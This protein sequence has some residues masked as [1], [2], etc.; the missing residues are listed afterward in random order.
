MLMKLRLWLLPLF[1]FQRFDLKVILLSLAQGFELSVLVWIWL[2]VPWIPL[3]LCCSHFTVRT[4]GPPGISGAKANLGWWCGLEL[5]NFI[6]LKAGVS[7]VWQW[8][9][10]NLYLI[11]RWS[12]LWRDVTTWGPTAV[13]HR[14]GVSLLYDW[15]S[16][17]R[18]GVREE[19]AGQEAM[20]QVL[21]H[22]SK[23]R[24]NSKAP[25]NLHSPFLT[26]V[27]WSRRSNFL[28]IEDAR[29]QA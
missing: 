14:L 29:P 13:L 3:W 12:D 17:P 1:I 10:P 27:F 24:I 11:R 20:L 7:F 19:D 6:I 2:R 25:P 9:E 26:G 15:L 23:L 22:N 8:A 5:G 4:P 21:G 28:F 16:T 18:P